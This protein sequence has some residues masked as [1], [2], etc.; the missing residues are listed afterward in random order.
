ML[1]VRI[2]KSLDDDALIQGIR[3]GRKR[4]LLHIYKKYYPDIRSHILK[5]SG[6]ENDA[7]DV[8]QDA[9]MAIFQNITNKDFELT[10]QYKTYLHAVSSN[11]WRKKLRN[12]KDKDFIEYEDASHLAQEEIDDAVLTLERYQ[13]Y[14]EKFKELSEKCQ[15]ILKMYLSGVHMKNIAEHFG[16]A[17]VSQTQKTKSTCNENLI[18]LIEKDPEYQTLIG[19]E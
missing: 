19:Y 16:F 13:F 18:K 1:R 2:S 7:Q 4:T 17:S 15:Q 12:S 3:K 8:F 11:I 6:S 10:C 14:Q 9:M 5:N